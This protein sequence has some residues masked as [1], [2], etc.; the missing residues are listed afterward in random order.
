MVE[1]VKIP[2]CKG[3]AGHTGL[4]GSRWYGMIGAWEIQGFVICDACYHDLVAWSQ[5]R[6]YFTTTPTIK[7]DEGSWTCD[8]AVP[9]IKEGLRRATTSPNLWDDL[10]L[11]FRRRMEYSSCMEMKNLQARST[12]WYGSKA[13]PDLIVCTTCYLDHF[14][15]DHARSWE[16]LSLTA[17]KQQQQLDCAMHTVQIYSAWVACKRVSIA[18]NTDEYDGFED[19]ARIILKSPPCSTED[20][21]NATW[22]TPQDCTGDAFAICKRCVLAFMVGPGFATEFKE[23]NFRRNG[24]WVC[25]LNPATPRF[26]KYLAKYEAAV[27]RENF[28]IFSEFVSEYAPLPDLL[29]T[30]RMADYKEIIHSSHFTFLVGEDQTPLTIYTAVVQ[31]N[32]DPLYALISNGHMKESNT[33]NAALEDVE[34]ETFMG[35]CEYAYTGAYVTPDRTLSQD[36]EGRHLGHEPA[37]SSPDPNG[38]FHAKLYVFATKYLIEPLRK[39]CLI[40][41]HRD[42]CSFS[43]KRESTPVILDLLDFTYA[44]SG[45]GE[46]G[47]KSLLRDLVI[48]YAAREARTLADDLDVSALVD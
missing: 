20:M 25:D 12:H 7:S 48:H 33:G 11:L 1:R 8:A 23:V 43:L 19:L 5:L 24:N 15:L 22:Y 32:S 35:F 44:H 38:L 34:V 47:G 30:R 28:S 9:L 6:R 36:D 17:E 3:P 2:A 14:V 21:R 42:L 39:Q 45:R 46:P 10:H 4:D 26:L 16:L 27:K 13:V 31:N 41:I 18:E 37:S 29:E 40:F